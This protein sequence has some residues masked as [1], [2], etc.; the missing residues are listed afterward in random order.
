MQ[1]AAA[2]TQR[3]PASRS[4]LPRGGGSA[5]AVDLLPAAVR[6]ALGHP[7]RRELG[8]ACRSHT[9]GLGGRKDN[10]ERRWG[11]SGGPLAGVEQ[12]EG[13]STAAAGTA[14]GPR[15]ERWE[16]STRP[17]TRATPASGEAVLEPASSKHRGPYD[18]RAI[19]LRVSET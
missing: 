4:R 18:T 17:G 9:L 8:G 12:R 5:A 3:R 10:R 11:R 15:S 6:D 7:S 2:R 14:G 13:C 16:G 1:S 19:S